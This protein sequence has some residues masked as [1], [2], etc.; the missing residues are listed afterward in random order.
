[1]T[2]I[3]ITHLSGSKANQTESFEAAR[4]EELILGRDSA[5]TVVFDPQRDDLVSRQHAAIRV[6]KDNPPSYLLVDKGSSNGTFHNGRP[7]KGAVTLAPG[8][9][10]E[11]GEGGP[12]LMFDLEPR[13]LPAV[14][15]TRLNTKALDETHVIRPPAS[16]GDTRPAVVQDTRRPASTAS[17]TA[18]PAADKSTAKAAEKPA[19]NRVGKETVMRMMD[20]QRRSTGR[21]LAIG[22]GIA[23]VLIAVIFGALVHFGIL[24]GKSP[25]E[26]VAEF[27]D[28]TVVVEA[29]YRIIDKSTGRA[30]Y[31]RTCVLEN[32]PLPCFLQFDNG[33]VM[34][35]LT[36]DDDDHRGLPIESAGSGSG[37][38]VNDSGFIL[39][40]KHVAQGWRVPQWD[41]FG[42]EAGI[43]I[44]IDQGKLQ[45]GRFNPMNVAS[46]RGWDFDNPVK[47]IRPD[48]R[49]AGGMGFSNASD[50][51]LDGRNES[52]TVRFP[53]TRDSID[54]QLVKASAD[55]D[56]AEIKIATTQKL[57]TINL[58]SVGS[59]PSVGERVTVLGYPG[60]SEQKVAIIQSSEGGK[61]KERVELIPQPTV[62]EGIIAKVGD[63][64]KSDKNIQTYD[65]LGDVY[66]LTVTATGHGNSGGPV[67]NS[68]GKVIG[69][70]TYSKSRG[71]ER[72]TF[73]VPIQYGLDLLLH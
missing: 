35:W 18:K 61:L 71:D 3:T 67:F 47:L 14:P 40:N 17:A 37:F 1:M 49:V 33:P 34:R 4:F 2:R 5:A 25:K 60:I 45:I 57:P 22:G 26:I 69:L 24:L 39:T 73:A 9:T 46:L 19:D 44:K 68:D 53:N 20:Q 62:T 31:Q 65:T 16:T 59:R 72:V 55:A 13:P 32:S 64:V 70:F 48:F 63:P 21:K 50:T 28:A 11:L 41:N 58:A 29:H 8:D 6:S 56:V 7:V 10:I 43:L 54:A 12:R 30:V 36:V 66:Q 42:V 52:L 23:V 51:M 15:P 27:G 38:V